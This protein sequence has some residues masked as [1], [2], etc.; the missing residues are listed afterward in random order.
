MFHRTPDERDR[1]MH[2][3]AI[4]PDDG[5]TYAYL[6]RQFGRSTGQ[7]SEQRWQWLMAAHI[8]GQQRLGL[9]LHSHLFM[10]RL[11][12][13]ERDW[14]EV[15]GQVLRLLLVPLGNGT[16]RLPLGNVGRATVSAFE[17]MPVAGP[18]RRLITEAREAARAHS[19]PP[20][21]AN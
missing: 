2:Q 1:S 20:K 19:S 15:A 7:S 13:S 16:G 3:Q 8:V 14:P 6:I 4:V 10:L 18:L 5:K 17:P 9:H 11:A 21:P 12:L